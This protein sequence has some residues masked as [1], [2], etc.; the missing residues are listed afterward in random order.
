MLPP[1]ADAVV[2][3]ERTQSL[4]NNEI[5]VL[6]PVAPGENLVQIGEDVA[7]GA[8]ILSA[9]HRIRP[10]DI[11]GLLAVGIL[12]IEV[13]V[14][15]RIGILSCGD[16]LVPPEDEPA[17]GQIRDINAYT[18]AGLIQNAGGNPVLL[19]MARDKLDDFMTRA[20]AGFKDVDILVM[21]AGSSVSVRDLT[22][23]VIGSLGK[24]GILQH[25]LAVKPG[26]PTII[27]VCDGKPVIGLP[28]N[29]VSALLVARQIV[30][31]IVKRA[32]GETPRPIATVRATLASNIPST[33]GRDDTVP[34]RLLERDS[35]LIA[36][37]VF[38]K[39]N[40]IYTLVAADGVVSVPLNSNG[41]KAGTVVEV[42]LF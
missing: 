36:E 30:V 37:P 13:V 2:M 9:G 33:T 3:V 32:L 22:R 26:K 4:G 34:V 5:E 8:E 20:H 42:V 7:R 18:L 16:E 6:A 31:P 25:G 24:P 40:L 12:S 21:T 23:E 10:Q 19:G 14:P 39:S 41:I 11:G 27:A 15:P 1:G 28:G 35:A 17:P 29:P 38:G